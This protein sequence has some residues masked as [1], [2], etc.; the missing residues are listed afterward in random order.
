M[1]TP[2]IQWGNYVCLKCSYVGAT[3]PKHAGCPFF[4]VQMPQRDT[5]PVSVPKPP[6]RPPRKRKAVKRRNPKRQ[7]SEFARCYHSKERVA[8]VKALPCIVCG[9]GP[10]DNAH[11]E[12]DGMGRKA[13]Y[14]KIV[15]LCC[16]PSD[17]PNSPGYER[18]HHGRMHRLGVGTFLHQYRNPPDLAA[19]AAATEKRWQDR[20][21]FEGAAVA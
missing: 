18:G 4:A 1:T 5:R 2:P 19:A 21:L 6:P 3:G 10:C 13:H 11:I 16:M 14:T 15:P 9:H 20:L 7:R 8:F 17:A 12:S